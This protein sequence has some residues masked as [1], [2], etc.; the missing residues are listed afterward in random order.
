MYGC[1]NLERVSHHLRERSGTGETL[2]KVDINEPSVEETE[3]ILKG[4][5]PRYES[6]HKVQILDSA[7][8]EA[9][10]LAGRYMTD[11]YMPDKA[12]DVMDEAAAGT[13]LKAEKIVDAE[14]IELTI[15][16]M[17]SIPPKRVERSDKERLAGL[18]TALQTKI[19]GQNEAVS[20]VCSAIK[21]ARSGLG[22]PRKPI[23]SFLFTGPTGV[24]KT[25]LCR[26]LAEELGLELIRFDMSEYM[27]PHTVSRLIGA[28]PG[29]VGFDQGG[30]LTDS[31]TK[32]PHSVV[33]L[34]EIEKAHPDIFNYCF[35]S[36]TMA[37]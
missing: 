35:K 18:E 34:D 5:R 10:Q 2:S 13:R 20:Q 22:N 25:E 4:L 29:Y 3:A 24:G 11:R 27:E 19:Y 17:A 14:V 9:A 37:A 30:L 31:V 7:L 36:W 23:A 26:Q 16:K 28:P 32:K 1:D 21:L 8:T 12:I 6:F 15:A 33:L